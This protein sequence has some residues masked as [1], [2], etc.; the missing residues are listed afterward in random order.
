MK[1]IGR[2]KN[3]NYWVT[4][5]EDGTKIRYTDDDVFKPQFPECLDMNITYKCD[6]GC[7]YC[8]QNATINGKHGRLMID[9]KPAHK[10]M[11]DLQPFTELALNANDLSHPELE[12]FLEFLKEKKVVAN[13]T[14]NQNHMARVDIRTKLRDWRERGLIYGI[15]LSVTNASDPSL[16]A[17]YHEVGGFL[18]HMIAGVHTV[19]DF[20][21][22]LV[23]STIQW[24]FLVLGYK[25]LGRGLFYSS[26]NVGT[27]K[28][29]LDNIQK[30]KEFFVDMKNLAA[31][32]SFDNLALKQLDIFNI[33]FNNDKEKW[34]LFFAGK[35][36]NFTFYVDMV[37]ETYAISSTRCGD[38]YVFKDS[39]FEM[40]EDVNKM[41]KEDDI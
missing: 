38:G 24:K 37:K 32:V 17:Y 3:G 21:H 35:D 31:G 36:G 5:L 33:W 29:V 8:Y 25:M 7:P 13:L 15:G 11:N 19:G 30:L 4:L 41:V 20:M 34:D 27:P 10:W 39:L 6:G 1:T 28:D 26:E 9:G 18:L 22:F 40:F 16:R 23:D 14:I 12:E 2:Y